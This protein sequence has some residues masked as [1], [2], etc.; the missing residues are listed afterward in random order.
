MRTDMRNIFKYK[1]ERRQK[2]MVRVFLA[3]DQPPQLCLKR[4]EQPTWSMTDL[5]KRVTG[6]ISAGDLL[7]KRPSSE[8]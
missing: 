5:A 4:N 7:A 8:S 6:E 1:R 3:K 2:E